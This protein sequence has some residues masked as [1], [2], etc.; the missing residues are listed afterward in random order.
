MLFFFFPLLALWRRAKP[1]QEGG[2]GAA[3]DETRQNIIPVVSVL[4]HSNDSH[5][6]GQREQ[7][8]AQGGLRQT[9]PF[10]PEHQGDVH[11]QGNKEKKDKPQRSDCFNV[12]RF[13]KNCQ[14]ER[15][16]S[17]KCFLL[18]NWLLFI[19]LELKLVLFF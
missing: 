9:G 12:Q 4:G 19:A 14:D 7:R 5:Q 10:G 6:H 16:L 18:K 11:L 1:H 13:N 2:D 8:Q 15:K 17:A 3:G